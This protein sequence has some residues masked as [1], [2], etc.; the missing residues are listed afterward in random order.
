MVLGFFLSERCFLIIGEHVKML[1][2]KI[3]VIIYWGHLHQTLISTCHTCIKLLKLHF[4][5]WHCC[6][7]CCYVTSVM[8][9]SVRPHTWQPTRLTHPWDSLGKNTGVGCHFLLQCMKVKSL[10]HVWCFM[11]PWTAANEAPLSMGQRQ[12]Y[13]SG[14]LWHYS[15][16]I[17]LYI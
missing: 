14:K 9:N 5:L 12:E 4:K 11:I 13:W 17:I 8:S 7:C 2:S 16:I 1:R 6:C 10:S 3:I 15:I